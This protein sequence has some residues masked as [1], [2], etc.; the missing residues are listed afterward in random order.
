MAIL[1]FDELVSAVRATTRYSS[2]IE[3][4]VP[5]E[6]SLV[7]SFGGEHGGS[8]AADVLTT[9]SGK[10]IVIDRDTDGRVRSIEIV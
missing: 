9:T 6:Q 7:I 8:E 1:T 2:D 10:E 5:V 3:K 4:G